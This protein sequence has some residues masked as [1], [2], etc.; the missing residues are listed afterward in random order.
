[1]HALFRSAGVC[2]GQKKGKIKG[3]RNEAT[4]GGWEVK[5]GDAKEQFSVDIFWI[6]DLDFGYFA[7]LVSIVCVFQLA[8]MRARCAYTWSV[9]VVKGGEGSLARWPRYLDATPAA[10]RIPAKDAT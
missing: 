10:G 5:E 6:I 1:M 3:R 4:G 7:V 2:G 9:P 8:T